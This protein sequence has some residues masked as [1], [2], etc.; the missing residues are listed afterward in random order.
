MFR[1]NFL[2]DGRTIWSRCILLL[3]FTKTTRLCADLNQLFLVLRTCLHTESWNCVWRSLYVVLF[4]SLSYPSRWILV[5]IIIIFWSEVHFLAEVINVLIDLRD[6]LELL[7]LACLIHLTR[8]S[9]YALTLQFLAWL[10]LSSAVWSRLILID[11]V[12]SLFW[13]L[14]AHQIGVFIGAGS[15]CLI[16][17]I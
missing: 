13:N 16:F 5:M 9:L 11:F 2:F 14:I 4:R 10:L 8:C 17:S 1:C 3:I 12:I 15:F 6:S 7:W